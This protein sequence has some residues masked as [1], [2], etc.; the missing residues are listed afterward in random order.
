MPMNK[1]P[2][3]HSIHAA[4]RLA[5]MLLLVASPLA[6]RYLWA[7]QPSVSTRSKAVPRIAPNADLSSR[8]QMA[9]HRPG[10]ATAENDLGPVPE[11]TVIHLQLL[12]TRDAA[13]EVAFQQRLADQQDP[14]SPW[15]HKWLTPAAIGTMYA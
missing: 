6:S 4:I 7:Q 14:S 13:R 10:W 8:H 15:Y 3:R 11:S 2:H 12:L 9:G 1:T 5:A